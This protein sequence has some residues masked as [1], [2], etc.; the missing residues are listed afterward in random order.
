MLA[1]IRRP[2]TIAG[3]VLLFLVLVGATYQGVATALERRR[4]P[5]PG[6]LLNVGDHQLHMYCRGTGTPTVVLEA[7][8]IAMSSVWGWVQASVERTTR[9]VAFELRARLHV[10]A[11]TDGNRAKQVLEKAERSCLISNSLSAE[12]RLIPTIVV[13]AE[14]V[15]ALTS[16]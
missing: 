12:I 10:P 14:P 3:V 8:E 15:S 7:P 16:V 5:H 4:F 11:G 13:A 1:S 2:V 9:V 6:R